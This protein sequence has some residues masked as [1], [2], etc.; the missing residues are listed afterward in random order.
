MAEV[1][2]TS[3]HSSVPEL[4]EA[5]MRPEFYPQ[6]PPKVELIQTH[7]SYVF[8]AGEF[9][10]KLKKAVHFSFLDCTTL[11]QRRHFAPRKSASTADSHPM[12]ISASIR[13]CRKASTTRSASDQTRITASSTTC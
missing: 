3:P 1:P 12:S 7:I 2:S 11:E 5:M 9:V 10:Y 8:L 13:F 4:V 6:P